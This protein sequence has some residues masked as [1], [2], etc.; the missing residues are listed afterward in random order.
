MS[1]VIVLLIWGNR[2]VLLE[3]DISSTNKTM[4]ISMTKA[5]CRLGP[6]MT[7]SPESWHSWTK[8]LLLIKSRANSAV[9]QVHARCMC[10]LGGRGQ[11]EYAS[12]SHWKIQQKQKKTMVIS[13]R[14]GSIE[15]KTTQKIFIKDP[16]LKELIY[17]NSPANLNIDKENDFHRARFHQRSGRLTW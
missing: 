15:S 13:G 4:K 14:K 10:P 6:L 11:K 9:C 17:P 16:V 2:Q 1:P 12:W 5:P 7:K 3:W 8:G